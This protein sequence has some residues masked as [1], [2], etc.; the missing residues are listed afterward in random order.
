[1]SERWKGSL[2][3]SDFLMRAGERGRESGE[4][5]REGTIDREE[6]WKTE[7]RKAGRKEGRE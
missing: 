1:M 5:G 6:A 3:L 4:R 2:A 7:R